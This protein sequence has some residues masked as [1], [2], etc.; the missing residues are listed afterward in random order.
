MNII[1]EIYYFEDLFFLHILTLDVLYIAL[2]HYKSNSY[3][4]EF[5]EQFEINLKFFLIL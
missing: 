4:G 1:K 5:L 3:I 2:G